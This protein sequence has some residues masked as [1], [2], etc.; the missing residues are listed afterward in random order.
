VAKGTVN[1]DARSNTRQPDLKRSVV[2]LTVLPN[3]PYEV[4]AVLTCRY[5]DEHSIGPGAKLASNKVFLKPGDDRREILLTI[6]AASC[7]EVPGKKSLTGQ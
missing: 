1:A 4:D 3:E 5:A 2:D 6:P 7:P